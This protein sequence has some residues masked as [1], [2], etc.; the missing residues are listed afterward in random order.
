MIKIF[1]KGIDISE[2]QG[3]VDFNKLKASGT[4]FVLLCAGYCIV[5]LYHEQYDARFEE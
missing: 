2:H 4:D 1:S 3:T 5:I